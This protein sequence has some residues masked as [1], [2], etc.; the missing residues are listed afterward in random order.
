MH[1]AEFAKDATSLANEYS[2]SNLISLRHSINQGY[3]GAG[4][5]VANPR[6]FPSDAG[7]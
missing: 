3:G 1:E 2:R 4:L 7:A 5:E 6:G